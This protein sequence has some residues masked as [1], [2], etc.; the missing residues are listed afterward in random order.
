[1]TRQ[2][3]KD[4]AQIEP[5]LGHLPLMAGVEFDAV[6]PISL[7]DTPGRDSGLY[8][9]FHDV[10]AAHPRGETRGMNARAAD[11]P[12]SRSAPGNIAPPHEPVL[13]TT[14]GPRPFIQPGRHT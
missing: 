7:N 14:P 12:A 11:D 6:R 9:G 3:S 10:Q 8:R 2:R 13:D 5:P 4:N 1:M